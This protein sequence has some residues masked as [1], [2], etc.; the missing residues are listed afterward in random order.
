MFVLYSGPTYIKSLEVGIV[1]F[2]QSI[3]CQSWSLHC[4]VRQDWFLT[5]DLT[6]AVLQHPPP[7]SPSCTLPKLQEPLFCPLLSW[8][9]VSASAREGDPRRLPCWATIL[10]SNL[11]SSSSILAAAQTELYCT[12]CLNEETYWFFEW[13]PVVLRTPRRTQT[14]VWLRPWLTTVSS[15]SLSPHGLQNQ[16]AAN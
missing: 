14:E 2:K 3:A 9:W 12:L 13:L 8:R 11:V 6:P 5:S 16:S 15:I 7:L 10:P 4:A 1:I